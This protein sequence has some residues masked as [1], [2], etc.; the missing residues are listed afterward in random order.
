MM[1]LAILVRDTQNEML[2]ERMLLFSTLQNNTVS[3]SLLF[4][5]A[6][7]AACDVLRRKGKPEV[8]AK[9]YMENIHQHQQNENN[10]DSSIS[11]NQ[12]YEKFT[13]HL[14]LT[15]C[16]AKCVM[17]TSSEDHPNGRK[18]LAM[19]IMKNCKNVEGYERVAAQILGMK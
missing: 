7:W 14:K 19:D 4:P 9:W 16:I 8:A 3:T 2:A 13:S 5:F 6:A 15:S 10:D 17:L 18:E 11:S 1:T 12:S